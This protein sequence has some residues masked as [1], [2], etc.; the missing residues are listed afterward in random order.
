MFPRITIKST[1]ANEIFALKTKFCDKLN[2]INFPTRVIRIFYSSIIIC[3]NNGFYNTEIFATS[4]NRKFCNAVK[5]E[6]SWTDKTQEFQSDEQVGMWKKWTNLFNLLENNKYNVIT[7]EI[8]GANVK[9][10]NYLANFIALM[11]PHS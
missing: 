3:S 4:S 6:N 9:V 1:R 8:S 5:T 10:A 11:L 2:E 7:A